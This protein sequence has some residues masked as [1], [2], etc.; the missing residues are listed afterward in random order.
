M[1]IRKEQDLNAIQT[2]VFD[3]LIG[4]NDEEKQVRKQRAS[5]RAL[6]ARRAIERHMEERNLTR[7]IDTDAWLE[8]A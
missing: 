4:F 7:H 6:E 2:E 1:L 5:R 8:D 3:I